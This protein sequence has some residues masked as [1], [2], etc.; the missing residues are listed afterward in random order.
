MDQN[1]SEWIRMDQNGSEWIRMDQNGSEWIKI[2][3]KVGNTDFTTYLDD[4]AAELLTIPL[5]IRRW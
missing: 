1:G 4:L 2:D 3:S 5:T